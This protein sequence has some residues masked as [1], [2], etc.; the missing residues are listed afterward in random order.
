MLVPLLLC[1]TVLVFRMFARWLACYQ[2]HSQHQHQVFITA[3]ATLKEQVGRNRQCGRACE[4]VCAFV[5]VNACEPVCL[6]VPVLED[7]SERA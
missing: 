2:H 7:D 4:C 1:S 5:C 3:S 6:C